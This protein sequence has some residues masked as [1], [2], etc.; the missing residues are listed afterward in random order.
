MRFKL[1]RRD[2]TAV[3]VNWIA[4]KPGA[5]K[6]E[7]I[8]IPCIALVYLIAPSNYSLQQNDFVLSVGTRIVGS[9]DQASGII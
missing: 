5:Q 1:D 3:R 6:M 8:L 2:R 9:A 4:S 7:C